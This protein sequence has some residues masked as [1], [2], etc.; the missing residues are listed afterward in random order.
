MNH[1]K[2]TQFNAAFFGYDLKNQIEPS[3]KSENTS[4]FEF[5]ELTVIEAEFK[6]SKH[7]SHITIESKIG[8]IDS[9]ISTI[10]KYKQSTIQINKPSFKSNT[11]KQEYIKTVENIKKHIEEGDIYEACYCIEYLD[12]NYISNS[13]ETIFKNLCLNSPTP[14]A[15]FVKYEDQ[16][17]MGA[18][19]ELFFKFDKNR[20]VS[21]PI[22]GTKLRGKTKQEDLEFINELKHSEKDKSENLMIVDL[23]RNDLSKISKKGTVKV[24]ELFGI[25]SYPTVHQMV[26]TIS[27]ETENETDFNSI[28]KALF[29]MGSMTG[30]PKIKAM[31]LID[32]YETFKRGLYRGSIGY[33]THQGYL[34]N[35]VIRTLQY[36]A[37]KQL[38]GYHVGS[39]ITFESDPGKTYEECQLKSK[40]L[41]N[42]FN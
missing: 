32:Q 25:Y 29:P 7:H 10:N 38:L 35:V 4:L 34:S 19:P 42:I 22:K 28:I 6:L 41:T 11:S 16:F 31:E 27:S 30:A 20:I 2:P 40:I 3:L 39:A 13:P 15:S 36:N 12:S 21:Q 8:N 1:F 18:S 37:K 17:I 33:F 24:E 23:V 5:P 26:S 9:L 14:F